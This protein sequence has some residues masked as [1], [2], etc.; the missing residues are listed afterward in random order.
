MPRSRCPKV[1]F[2]I[3]GF[4]SFASVPP[5]RLVRHSSPRSSRK[6]AGSGTWEAFHILI[7][8]RRGK[9]KTTSIK[10]IHTPI[11]RRRSGGGAEREGVK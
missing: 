6:S 4:E 8:A 11:D 10:K 7:V 1:V 2:E 3:F 5:M 9:S